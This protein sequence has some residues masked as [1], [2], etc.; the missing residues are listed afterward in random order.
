MK[1]REKWITENNH[2]PAKE[3]TLNIPERLDTN[4]QNDK[5]KM[6]YNKPINTKILVVSRTGSVD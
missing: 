1:N 2:F 3:N 6:P 5:L 4:F